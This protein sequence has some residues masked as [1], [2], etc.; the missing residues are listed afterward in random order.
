MIVH[1]APNAGRWATDAFS[2]TPVRASNSTG[3]ATTFAHACRPDQARG[4]ESGFRPRGNA[5]PIDS[6]V[7]DR[8]PIGASCVPMRRRQVTAESTADVRERRS[9][10]VEREILVAAVQLL[11]YGQTAAVADAK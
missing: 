4:A 2:C 7:E 11:L 8:H 3:S 6:Q 1:G 9:Y 10:P 5:T